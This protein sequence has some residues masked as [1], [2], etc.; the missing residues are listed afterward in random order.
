MATYYLV[1]GGTGN[2]NSSTNWSSSSGGVSGA[3][4]PGSTDSVIVDS[5]SANTNLT[6]TSASGSYASLIFSS[7]TG[8]L[9]LNGVLVNYGNLTLSAGMK[10]TGSSYLQVQAS[11]TWNFNGVTW[12]PNIYIATNSTITLSSN[13]VV[14]GYINNVANSTINGFIITLNGSLTSAGSLSGSTS[15][16]LSGSGNFG[17]SGSGAYLI[18]GGI[19]IN[20]SGT[21]T[22]SSLL[23]FQGITSLT[24][25]AGTVITTGNTMVLSQLNNSSS[26]TLNTAGIVWNNIS[27]YQYGSVFTLNSALIATG[28]LSFVGSGDPNYFYGSYGFTVGSITTTIAGLTI[29]LTAANTYT[30]TNSFNMT[31]TSASHIIVKSTSTTK[32]K[33]NLQTGATQ[34]L[35]YVDGQY[36]DSSGGKTIVSKG[37]VLTN[38]INWSKG[39]TSMLMF[40]MK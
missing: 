1:P 6:I 29:V 40:F 21:I 3:G 32:A 14:S 38:T 33:L 39:L 7:Y 27:V 19:T 23:G 4:I 31:G 8:T 18:T 16:V 12:G 34:S 25:V 2:W 35:S 10:V 24:Y 15:I 26:I 30:I 13:I 36:I 9:T 22:L 20:T 11:G 37:G 5:N 28:T 17:T